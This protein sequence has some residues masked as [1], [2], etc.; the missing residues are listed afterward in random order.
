MHPGRALTT[1][2]LMASTKHKTD[3]ELEQLTGVRERPVAGAGE[4][5]YT[6]A[7]GAAHDA[8]AHAGI[9]ADDLDMLLVSSISRHVGGL[10]I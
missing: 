8:L 6:L 4:D 10:R 9:D 7:L 1:D 3:I 2:E 5:L